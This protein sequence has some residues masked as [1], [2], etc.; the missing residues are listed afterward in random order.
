[1]VLHVAI[2]ILYRSF[3]HPLT[4]GLTMA[5]VMVLHAAIVILYRRLFMDH[6]EEQGVGAC[7]EGATGLGKAG[8]GGVGKVGGAGQLPPCLLFPRAEM[9]VLPLLLVAFT[10]YACLVLN[11]SSLPWSSASKWAGAQ[12][13]AQQPAGCPAELS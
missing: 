2:V 8:E 6:R 5:I 13:Q 3:P 12:M 1:M 7:S 4:A 11:L 9:A 10:F